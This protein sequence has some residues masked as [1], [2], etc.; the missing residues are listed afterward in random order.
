MNKKTWFSKTKRVGLGL[1]LAGTFVSSPA[2]AQAGAGTGGG[3]GGGGGASGASFTMKIAN[4][5]SKT[6]TLKT[7]PSGMVQASQN[8]GAGNE[9]ASLSYDASLKTFVVIHA[10]NDIFDTRGPSAIK[11]EAVLM[12]AT[13]APTLVASRQFTHSNSDR[14]GHAAVASNGAGKFLVSY[15]ANNIQ[16][17]G[18]TQ[19]YALVTDGMCNDLTA[20]NYDA[21]T[22][23]NPEEAHIVLNADPNNNEAAPRAVFDGSKFVFGYYSNNNAEYAELVSIRATSTGF[24]PFQLTDPQRLTPSNIGRPQILLV[25]GAETTRALYAAPKGNQR[26]SEKGDE[27]ALLNTDVAAIQTVNGKKQMPVMWRQV[28]VQAQPDANNIGGIDG[29]PGP[30]GGKG[31]YPSAP[32]LAATAVAGEVHLI[33]FLSTGEGRNRN[34]KGSSISYIAKLKITDTGFTK[35]VEQTDV[36]LE[37]SHIVACSGKVGTIDA[38]GVETSEHLTAIYG[39]PITG[40]GSSSLSLLKHDPVA[41]KFSMVASA[42]VSTDRT[43]G[44]YLNN[45]LGR[46]PNTQGREHLNCVG[47]VENLAYHAGWMQKVKTMWATPWTGRVSIDPLKQ[48][49]I[50]SADGRMLPEDRNALYLTFTAAVRD[51]DLPPPAP[52]AAPDPTANGNGS[53]PGQTGTTPPGTGTDTPGQTGGFTGGCSFGGDASSTGLLGLVLLGGALF[54]VRRRWT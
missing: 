4:G 25:P 22:N 46:N 21:T 44:G 33:T 48:T 32:T 24:E 9:H 37:S 51:A 27:V 29:L 19:T 54:L 13:G 15:G 47:N 11:C 41:N 42:A 8:K 52:P 35:V 14:L 6:Q 34:K 49:K 31:I 36:S 40:F 23:R 26:P 38:A 50:L 28:V 7:L 53:E 16:G 20:G 43:D 10:T 39:A 18:N 17:N 30:L 45:M 12:S 1:A 2:F 3:T 5:V